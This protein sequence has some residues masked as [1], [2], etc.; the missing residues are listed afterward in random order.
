MPY[1]SLIEQLF[2]YSLN[3]TSCSHLKVIWSGL[4]KMKDSWGQVSRESFTALRSRDSESSFRAPI[5]SQRD[6]YLSFRLSMSL[7]CFA[8]DMG[9][10]ELFTSWW[11]FSFLNRW[12]ASLSSRLEITSVPPLPLP[13]VCGWS[14]FPKDAEISHSY[15]LWSRMER[16]RCV[17]L[18]PE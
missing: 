5:S 9:I 18:N 11:R 16:R 3:S 15:W 2:W 1:L 7:L 10:K 8:C 13:S 12:Q 14:L 17:W 4:C 6:S